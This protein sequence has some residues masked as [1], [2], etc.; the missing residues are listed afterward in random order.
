MIAMRECRLLDFCGAYALVRFGVLYQKPG[1]HF[2]LWMIG[3][4]PDGRGRGVGKKLFEHS[5][6]L[7][8]HCGFKLAFAECTGAIS[9][10]IFKKYVSFTQ[11]KLVR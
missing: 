1:E 10:H 3:V 6:G 9:T 5:I 2:H 4:A 8:R 11:R 7:A